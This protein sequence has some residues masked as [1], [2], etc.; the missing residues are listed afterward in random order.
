M[1]VLMAWLISFALLGC[2]PSS[3]FK[4]IPDTYL[5]YRKNGSSDFEI[6][7]AL[8]ECGY[9][10]PYSGVPDWSKDVRYEGYY[11]QEPL[12]RGCML[13]GG[14][15]DKLSKHS[16]CKH[17]NYS[18]TPS[19]QPDA[20]I[21]T[22]SIQRRL[23][24]P[25]CK[26]YPHTYVCQNDYTSADSPSI[27]DQ[28]DNALKEHGSVSDSAP[29]NRERLRRELEHQQLQHDIQTQTNRQMNNLLKN[30]VPKQK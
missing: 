6:Q 30:T 4:P 25:Y 10:N 15:I 29:E 21:P 19:C 12:R 16:L 7:K 5:L 22:R 1:R 20:I 17:P 3:G 27:K 11:E 28:G 8:L 9:A 26:K 14:F 24:S 23:N 2:T 18:L 13:K